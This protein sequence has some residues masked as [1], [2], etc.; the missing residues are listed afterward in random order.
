VARY[1]HGR[2]DPT[3]ARSEARLA[4]RRRIE[5]VFSHLIDWFDI[6]RVRVRD[7]WHL[8]HRVVRKILALTGA[9]QLEVDA[10]RSP[11]RLEPLVAR[12]RTRTRGDYVPGATGRESG[13][14]HKLRCAEGT[15]SRP[16]R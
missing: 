2:H 3:P 4:L 5:T 12:R 13:G 9:A 11:R 10:G 14:G 15:G 1:K 7:L 16:S 8:E 6:R